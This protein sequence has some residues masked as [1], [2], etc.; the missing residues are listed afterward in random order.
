MA[1]K[2]AT[3]EQSPVALFLDFQLP[4]MI[5]ANQA[6]ERAMQHEMAMEDN[7]AE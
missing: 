5:A 3:Y 7:R 2:R 1:L 4:Q 6:R